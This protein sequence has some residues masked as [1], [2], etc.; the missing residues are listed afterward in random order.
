MYGGCGSKVVQEAMEKH[1]GIKAGETTPDGLFTLIEVECLGACV[2]A[3]MLQ[4]DA[5]DFYEDLTPENVVSLLDGLRRG[6]KDAVKPGPQNGKR[7]AAEGP[8]GKTS[9]LGP[10]PYGPLAAPNLDKPVAP[11]QPP[12]PKQA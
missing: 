6:G 10:A 3:P 9:L 11:P 2:N 1:L 8:Q 12:P 5:D 7:R 4:L